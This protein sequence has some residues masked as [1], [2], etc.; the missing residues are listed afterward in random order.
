[1]WVE[2]VRG[3]LFVDAMKIRF[4]L[5]LVVLLAWS[6]TVAGAIDRVRVDLDYVRGLAEKRAAK[7]YRES[8]HRLPDW[9]KD[10]NY[11]QYQQ[12]RFS[13]DEALW[14]D[15]GLPFQVQ[16]FHPGGLFQKPVEI[17]EFTDEHAQE[18]PF[19]SNFFSYGPDVEV[20][21]SSRNL[22]YAGLKVLYPLNRPGHFDELVVFLGASY[23]RA[24]GRGQVYG[25][26][27]RGIALD[28]GL[29]GQE[30]F[31][32][33]VSFWLGKPDPETTAITLYALLDGPSLAGAYCFRVTPGESTSIEVQA[34]LFLREEVRALGL[35][36][37]TS[38]FWY[39]ENSRRPGDDYRPEVHDS[40]GL[41]LR[42]DSGRWLWRPLN[43]P[44]G[45][46]ATDLPVEQLDG[47]GLVQRDRSFDHYQDF[48]A[49]FH[50]RPSAWVEPLG[51]WGSGRVR[52]V[53]LPTGNEYQDNMVA[54][55]IPDD[56][57]VPG[58]RFDFAYRISWVLDR[59][60]VTPAGR[61]VSTRTGHLVDGGLARLFVVDFAGSHLAGLA[62]DEPVDVVIGVPEGAR[63]L[64]SEVKKNPDSDTWRVSF[65]VEADEAGSPIDLHCYL[66]SGF[67]QLTETWV[68][69]WHP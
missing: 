19:V 21:R 32:G 58:E 48:M 69:R 31:P 40:D 39:G 26:S 7:P 36:P 38:M 9:L 56:S 10:L 64:H 60:L 52:L 12:I 33:F 46:E 8:R 27:A 63:F 65:G 61:V 6:C 53:E 54:F 11:S 17:F 67:E 5:C 30:E 51:D 28:T 37:L 15:E 14:A 47:F 49:D 42:L 29:D 66:S 43:N 13:P 35:A 57:P 24:L 62:A 1:M 44:P 45:V 18:I 3:P 59:G 55:W 2:E 23:F 34:S 68:Y 25:L 16:F 4:R 50:L 20:G 22:G 41:A